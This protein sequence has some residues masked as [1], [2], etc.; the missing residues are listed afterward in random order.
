MREQPGWPEHAAFMNALAAS[1]FIV[2]GGP[3]SDGQRVLH[4][5][6]A[7]SEQA[8]R[9]RLAQD[10]WEAMGMLRTQSVDPWQVLLDRD[11]QG[12]PGAG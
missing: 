2:R 12:Q 1:R 4:I 7:E 11:V 10:P 8:V 3:L 6:E 9:D 5:V